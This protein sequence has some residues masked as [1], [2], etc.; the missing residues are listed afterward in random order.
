MRRRE[1]RARKEARE[2]VKEER[3]KVRMR[4]EITNVPGGTSSETIQR[5]C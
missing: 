3:K 5:I 1:Q 2:E 4:K